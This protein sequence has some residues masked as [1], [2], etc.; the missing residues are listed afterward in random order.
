VEFGIHGGKTNESGVQESCTRVLLLQPVDW[1]TL[2]TR[3]RLFVGI[4][5]RSREFS[6]SLVLQF[7][8]YQYPTHLFLLIQ[9]RIP[10]LSF[11]TGWK[12]GELWAFKP[13]EKWVPAW[14]NDIQS[15]VKKCRILALYFF[16]K[17]RIGVECLT[18]EAMNGILIHQG[19]LTCTFTA[20]LDLIHSNGMHSP[21]ASWPTLYGNK[22]FSGGFHQHK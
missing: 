8:V 6:S 3:F 18:R 9:C 19:L 5:T 20:I 15:L 12:N 2:E 11:K 13:E 10:G 1:A 7:S 14:W 4:T 16:P 22:G 17:W 21:T